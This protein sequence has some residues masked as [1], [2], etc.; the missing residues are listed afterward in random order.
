[1]TVREGE[2]GCV[3]GYGVAVYVSYIMFS[4]SVCYLCAMRMRLLSCASF[5]C[6]CFANMS[7]WILSTCVRGWADRCVVGPIVRGSCL[8]RC[9]ADRHMARYG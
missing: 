7:Y 9:L 4:M 2:E 8:V 5:V 1:M 6:D 3:E